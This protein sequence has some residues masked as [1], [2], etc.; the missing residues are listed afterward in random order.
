MDDTKPAYFDLDTV[1]LLRDALDEAWASLQP[2][3]RETTSRTILA[4]RI[5]K[6]A[7]KGERDSAR[8]IGGAVKAAS[9][10]V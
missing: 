4:E 3:L 8:L 5:L 6:E 9:E 7:A 2:R 10:A 1:V